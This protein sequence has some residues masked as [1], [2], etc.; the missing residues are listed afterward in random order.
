MSRTAAGGHA[1]VRRAGVLVLAATLAGLVGGCGAD[2][3]DLPAR[4]PGAGS[5]AG[6]G[7]AASPE[8]GATGGADAA[9][10]AGATGATGVTA[11]EDPSGNLRLLA[12]HGPPPLDAWSW[13]PAEADTV[14]RAVE[15]LTTRCM[16][17]RGFAYEPAG[18]PGGAAPAGDPAAP[19]VTVGEPVTHWGGFLGLVSLERARTTGYQVLGADARLAARARLER[20]AARAPDPAYVAAL[21]GEGAPDAAGTTGGGCSGW[22]FDRVTPADPRV[23]RRIQERLYGEALR[24]AEQDPA[25]VRA[26]AG[27][28]G[29]MAGSGYPLDAVPVPASTDPV[30]PA[31][32]EQAVADVR[33]KDETGLV[34]TYVTALYGAERA[35]GEEH[36]AELDAFAAWG[37]E[38]VRLAG[39]ALAG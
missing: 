4:S 37:R 25:V 33:C 17:G 19:D 11:D 35:L 16:A 23:D 38:R 5:G 22:A 27:W 31:L 30:T 18:S 1:T 6:S 36:R 12:R 28:T 26:L 34:E 8:G 14:A 15:E 24:R 9:D 29:C 32:V 20:E 13:T 10:G 21:T 39:E 7:S 3:A 2:P